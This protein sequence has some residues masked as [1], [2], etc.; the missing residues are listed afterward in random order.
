[1]LCLF[2][3]VFLSTPVLYIAV[4][5][6]GA[7][8]TSATSE[9]LLLALHL[10]LLATPQLF[11]AHGL[12]PEIWLQI[13]SL[14]LPMDESYGMSLGACFGA[15]LGAVPI[16]LDW[17]RDWQRWPVTIVVG[18]YLGAVAGKLVG[19]YILKGRLMR[20]T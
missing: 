17:D 2:L 9:T 14:R 15:W 12:K 3:T 18:I 16:P 7:P 20:I 13:A 1:M 19:G 10:A 8:L 11:Y 6:F 5:L 4:I